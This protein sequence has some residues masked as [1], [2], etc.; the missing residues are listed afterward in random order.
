M[1][2]WFKIIHIADKHLKRVTPVSILIKTI[3]ESK[4]FLL[5]SKGVCITTYTIHLG[6]TSKNEGVLYNK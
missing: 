4:I 3:R 6:S 5:S 2:K 1:E